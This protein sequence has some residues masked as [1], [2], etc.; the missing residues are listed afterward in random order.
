MTAASTSGNAVAWRYGRARP[1]P[2]HV[3]PIRPK[4]SCSKRLLGINT[5]RTD[6]PHGELP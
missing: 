1:T 4:T 2:G 3:V 6:Y 5:P